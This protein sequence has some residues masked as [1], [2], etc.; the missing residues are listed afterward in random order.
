[1]ARVKGKAPVLGVLLV[2]GQVVKSMKPL[3]KGLSNIAGDAMLG[4][5]IGTLAKT[6]LD[7]PEPVTP[8]AGNKALAPPT[9]SD[10]PML[11]TN[12]YDNL[13]GGY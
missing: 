13:S 4:A 10:R 2:G 8:I 11:T 5:G 3:P 7:P 9:M 6:I 12:P 1:M